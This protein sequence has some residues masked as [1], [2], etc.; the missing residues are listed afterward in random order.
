MPATSLSEKIARGYFWGLAAKWFNRSVGLISLLILAR[1]LTPDDF[2]VAALSTLVVVL[3]S[4]LAES[5]SEKYLLRMSVCSDTSMNSAWS[6]NV[7]LKSMAATLILLTS[8]FIAE[9]LNEPRL[10]PVLWVSALLLPLRALANIGLILFEREMNFRPKSLLMMR[11]KLCAFPV[12]VGLAWF[13]GSYWALILGIVASDIVITV[14]SYFIHPYRPRWSREQWHEQ[15]QFS[16]WI[17]VMSSTGALRSRIDVLMMGRF[18]PAPDIGAYR[19]SQE[20][21]WLPFSELIQPVTASLYAGF[22][23]LSE[24]K[25]ALNQQLIRYLVLAYLLVIPAA[26]GIFLI[27][28]PLTALLL[29]E[30][31]LPYA[32]VLAWVSLLMLTMP[33]NLGMQNALV[34]LGRAHLLAYIDLIMIAAIVTS[35]SLLDGQSATVK[36][37]SLIDF[38]QVRVALAALFLLSLLVLYRNVLTYSVM[39]LLLALTL[40]LLPAAVMAWVL[41]KLIPIMPAS[42]I[43]AVIGLSIIGALV[44]VLLLVVLLTQTRRWSPYHHQCWQWLWK[45]FT[46]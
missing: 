43:L 20:I 21:G 1:L 6:L 19:M 12:S 45:K 30:K 39:P 17:M 35:F 18:L 34:S 27:A 28:E 41:W 40:P 46:H 25:S 7:A 26:T 42:P 31:W 33:L 15:W 23:S 10:M 3:F 2:G 36:S 4:T 14:G 9:W 22:A 11:A 38:T 44:Y 32:D 24:Q 13:T 16:R 29:G 37:P 5:G 8:P